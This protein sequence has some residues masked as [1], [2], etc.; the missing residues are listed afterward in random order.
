MCGFV[1]CIK[2]LVHIA[3]FNNNNAIDTLVGGP[4]CFIFFHFLISCWCSVIRISISFK[5]S[6]APNGISI[7][8]CGKVCIRKVIWLSFAFDDDGCGGICSATLNRIK[9][10][11]DRYW[12][13]AFWVESTNRSHYLIATAADR[14]FS[15]VPLCYVWVQFIIILFSRNIQ[16]VQIVIALTRKCVCDIRTKYLVLRIGCFECRI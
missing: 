8:I 6:N 16:N 14:G 15:L 9:F 4:S 1:V 7:V 10:A 13:F 12:I 2:T 5:W 3:L 11:K